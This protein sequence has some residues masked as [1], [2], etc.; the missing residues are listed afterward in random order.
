VEGPPPQPSVPFYDFDVPVAF[1]K[2]KR[3]CTDHPI[4]HFVLYDRL[5]HFFRQFTLSLSVSLPRS[6]EKAILIPVWKQV[7][8]EEMYAVNSRGT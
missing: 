3:S 4:S 7:M 6:Y 5:T 2:G 1:C 8:G